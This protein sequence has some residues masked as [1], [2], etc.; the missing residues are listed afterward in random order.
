M[1]IKNH[2]ATEVTWFTYLEQGSS[3]NGH[4]SKQLERNFFKVLIFGA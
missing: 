1:G 4:P 2:L 3:E